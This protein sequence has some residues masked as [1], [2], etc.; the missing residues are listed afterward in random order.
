MLGIRK[1]M[2]CCMVL[3]LCPLAAWAAPIPGTANT[4]TLSDGPNAEL[5]FFTINLHSE[6]FD[7]TTA[8]DPLGVT[9]G[10]TQ[11]AYMLEYVS[12]NEALSVLD[13]ESTSSVPILETAVS[14]SGSVNGQAAG[15]IAPAAHGVVTL[16]GKPAARFLFTESGEAFF[17]PAGATSNILVFTTDNSYPVGS[18]NASIRD[19]SLSD[20]SSVVGPTDLCPDDPNKTQPGACGCGIPDTDS[21]GAGLPDCLDGC[22]LD[23][24]KD[25]PGVC[26]C[27]T[28]D[29]DTDGDGTPNCLDECIEDPLKTSPGACGCGVSDLDT[30]EDGTADCNDQCPADPTKTD[31]GYCGCGIPDV[32]SDGD[33]VPDCLDNCP[34]DPDKVEPGDCG[35]GAPETDSD[36]DGY[37]D[38]V[39]LCPSDPGKVDPGLC[40][41]GTSESD[42]DND[43]VPDC[44]DRCE[45]QS[46][47][48]DQDNDGV[49]DCLDGCPQDAG[50][51]DPGLCGC[52]VPDLDSDGDHVPDCVDGCP[53]DPRKSSPGVC[54]C[55]VSD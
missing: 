35:C 14:T 48:G 26:G 46:D 25:V 39:D 1:S 24:E 32:D 34:T 22:P 28:S 43:G 37:P 52:G 31:L 10:K 7:G 11:Y 47:T 50:K 27:G 45:G 36:D 21:D 38:C 9:P 41:C 54:G 44:I 18:V 51:V 53:N 15:S 33:G 42:S 16:G 12:G 30:D 19:T 40:G 8:S 2:A 20:S 4:V 49:V 13:V 5:L 6:A 29:T 55:G 3:L 23:P 17:Q